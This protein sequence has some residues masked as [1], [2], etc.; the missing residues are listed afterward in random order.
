MMRGFTLGVVTP[1]L[2]IVERQLTYCIAAAL[3][4]ERKTKSVLFSF[5]SK[6]SKPKPFTQPF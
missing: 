4:E 5:F 1:S 3:K 2:R 6:Q